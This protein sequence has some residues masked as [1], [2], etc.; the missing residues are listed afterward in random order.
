[1]GEDEYKKVGLEEIRI[2]EPE[3][4]TGLH[5]KKSQSWWMHNSGPVGLC[6]KHTQLQISFWLD[7]PST[8]AWIYIIYLASFSNSSENQF[9]VRCV[10]RPTQI[11]KTDARARNWVNLRKATKRAKPRRPLKLPPTTTSGWVDNLPPSLVGRDPNC[12]RL[13]RTGQCAKHVIREIIIGV[14]HGSSRSFLSYSVVRVQI[15]TV[16]VMKF[17]S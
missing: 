13:S 15:P 12:S 6:N 11:E 9:G 10:P 2:P 7:R 1:M 14:K 8:V 16:K 17:H 4:K 3:V 5:L